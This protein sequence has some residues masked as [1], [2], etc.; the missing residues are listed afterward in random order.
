M[1]WKLIESILNLNSQKDCYVLFL[2]RIWSL[3]GLVLQ[4]QLSFDIKC[5]QMYDKLL[6]SN[7][8]LYLIRALGKSA[9]QGGRKG[10]VS[11]LWAIDYGNV[12][13]AQKLET[14]HMFQLMPIACEE[15]TGTKKF[16]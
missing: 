4:F 2:F 7:P 14:R 3:F 16:F 9:F 6:I 8:I 11:L 5:I 13:I 10:R 12:R 1:K 15:F